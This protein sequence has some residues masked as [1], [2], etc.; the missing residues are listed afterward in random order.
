MSRRIYLTLNECREHKVQ[1]ISM[2]EH[3][4]DGGGTGVR[5][6]DDKCCGR[7]TETKRWP[8]SIASLRRIA[9]ECESGIDTL[10]EEEETRDES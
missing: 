1:S 2:D 5:L 10:E 3:D 4:D 9:D 8:M 6:T 7:W